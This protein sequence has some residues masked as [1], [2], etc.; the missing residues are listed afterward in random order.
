MLYLTLKEMRAHA[1]RLTGTS[2]AVVLGVAFL[3]GT[4]VLGATLRANFDDLF[5]EV[6]AGTDVVVRNSTDL[7][8][9]SPRGLIDPSLVDQVAEV[10]GVEAAEPVVT[11]YGQLLGADGDAI[12]GNGPPQL[13]GSWVT[14]PDLNP[15]RLAEGRAPEGDD[16]VVVNKGTLD[17]GD[18]ALG[19][20]TT[21]LTPEPV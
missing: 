14:D 7:G 12:G 20:T 17:A 15:Y 16:E 13:A 8:M 1:R 19:D 6:N 18:L 2:L 21:L 3:T 9:D 4:L 5:T 11:G 10:D